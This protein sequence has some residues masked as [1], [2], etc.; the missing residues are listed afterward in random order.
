MTP[1]MGAR[2]EECI[3]VVNCIVVKDKNL[4]FSPV[5]SNAARFG[6]YDRRQ[7]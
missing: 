6:L 1:K 7:E 5:F 2:N 3:S 4:L